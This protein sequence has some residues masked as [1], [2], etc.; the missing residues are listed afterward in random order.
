[1]EW[2]IDMLKGL[3]LNISESVSA[4][5]TFDDVDRMAIPEAVSLVEERHLLGRF[6]KTL[7]WSGRPKDLPLHASCKA[8]R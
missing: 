4:P 3:H 1:M 5:Q 8:S 6:E 2:E 7:T